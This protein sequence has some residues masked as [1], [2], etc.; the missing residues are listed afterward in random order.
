MIK[1]PIHLGLTVVLPRPKALTRE[2]KSTGR[3]PMIKVKGDNDNFEKCVYD[4]MEGIVYPNDCLIYSNFT[5]T[6]YAAED[7]TPHVIVL[8]QPRDYVPSAEET[9]PDGRKRKRQADSER[10][11]TANA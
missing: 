6:F 9:P 1:S 7:E 4:A 2:W 3:V 11:E 5:E 10:N 8:V